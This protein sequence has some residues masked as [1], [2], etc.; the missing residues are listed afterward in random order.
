ML[1]CVRPAAGLDEAEVCLE[2]DGGR[3]SPATLQWLGTLPAGLTSAAPAGADPVE[4]SQAA[5]RCLIVDCRARFE[6]TTDSSGTLPLVTTRLMGMPVPLVQASVQPF[7]SRE[8]W[9]MVAKALGLDGP[10]PVVANE[11]K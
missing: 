9:P 8:V 11:K 3:L 6:G 1:A 4:F 10:P 7:D 5:V 2:S